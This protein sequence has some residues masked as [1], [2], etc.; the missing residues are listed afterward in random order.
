ML[1]NIQETGK[2]QFIGGWGKEGGTWW[3]KIDVA[4]RSVWVPLATKL[5]ILVVATKTNLRRRAQRTMV[6]IATPFVVMDCH[7]MFFTEE[8]ITFENDDFVMR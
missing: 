5:W 1:P 7:N 2:L 3:K 8:E 4:A 6:L